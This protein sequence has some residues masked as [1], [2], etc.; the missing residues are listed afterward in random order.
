MP[1]GEAAA[2]AKEVRHATAGPRALAALSD[3]LGLAGAAGGWRLDGACATGAGAEARL[4]FAL[5]RGAHRLVFHAEPPGL[6]LAPDGETS[7]ATARFLKATAARFG[8]RT[9]ADLAALVDADPGSFVESLPPGAGGDRVRVPCIGQPLGLLESGWRNFYADQD[10]EVLLG[11]PDCVSD[12][13]INVE[14]ADLECFYARPKRSFGKWTFLDWPEES[15]DGP[16][17]GDADGEGQDSNIVAELEERDMIL[18][19]SERA[20]ALVEEVRKRAGGADYIL[21]THLCTPIVMGEDMQGLARRCEEEVGGSAVRWSQKDRDGN[22]NFGEHFRA[23]VARPGFLD[24]APDPAAVNLFHFPPAAREA[25]LKPFLE[26]LGLTVNLSV[27]PDVRLGDLER[28]GRGAFDAFCA[29]SSYPTKV[30]E[31]LSGAGRRTVPVPAPYGVSGTRACLAAL[32]AAAGKTVEFERAWAAKE[33][34]FRPAWEALRKDAAGHRLAFVV[35]EATL[36]RLL[37]LRYGHGAPL[38]TMA[39]EIG[40][41]L[42]LVYYDRHGEPPRLPEA[43]GSA[44]VSVFRTPRELERVLREGD[45]AAVYSDVFFDPRV[46]RAGKARFSSKDFEMGLEGARR[47]AERLLAVCRLPFY[48]RYAAHLRAGPGGSD[49]L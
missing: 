17:S 12:R 26:T 29:R 8:A 6:T 19:T 9:T 32:A 13:T 10:F 31:I 44:R 20:E 1:L 49:V 5:S 41:G 46:T 48:R 43:L 45:F 28:L 11:V 3:L 47:T 35:S 37:E 14:Y 34:A 2:P 23:L 21:F 18:G 33:A 22:D 25:E 27:F 15:E 39:A 4:R 16:R 7:P 40:F 38:A 42:D 36:P 24:A 30:R